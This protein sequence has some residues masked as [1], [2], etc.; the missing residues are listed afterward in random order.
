M[1]ARLNGQLSRRKALQWMAVAGGCTLLPEFVSSQASQI[2]SVDK[3]AKSTEASRAFLI[4]TDTAS[5]DAVALVMALRNPAIRVEAITVVAGN[6]NVD[7]GVQNALYTCEL[8][9]RR[10][11]V[12]RGA[13]TPLVRPYHDAEFVHG[14]DGMGDIGLPLHGRSK[15]AGHAVPV[16]LDTLRRHAGEITLVSLGPLTNIALA[17]KQDP[18]IA[19]MV[20]RY[21]MMGGIGYGPGNITPVAEY[22]IWVDPDAA[23]IVFESGLP[24]EMVGWDI[25][26]QAAVF[27][28]AEASRLRAIG[29]P[30]ARFCVDIQKKLNE[31]DIQQ[32]NLPGFDLPD[33]IAMAVAIDPAVATK[34]ERAYVEV[35]TQ[36]VLSLGQTVVDHLKVT[37]KEPNTAIV[38]E[39]SREKFLKI[40]DDAVRS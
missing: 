7:K 5:D 6:V 21:V 4:D 15:T 25:S 31:F 16:I 26:V 9:D 27:D 22:N 2:L 10:V 35:E 40:L 20:K 34:V 17:L 3:N 13:E 37:G 30:L 36:G 14:R 23:K 12:Y 8:C 24:I 19:R 29:T 39:A 18:S 38:R 32:G 1:R 33:P 11:P 28:P